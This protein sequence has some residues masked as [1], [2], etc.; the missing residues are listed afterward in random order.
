MTT[1][2]TFQG[3]IRITSSTDD[4]YLFTRQYMGYSMRD[5]KRLFRAELRTANGKS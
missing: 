2:R 1:E 5:A 4:G 3:A